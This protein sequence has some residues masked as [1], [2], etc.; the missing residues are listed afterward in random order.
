VQ[1]IA[2]RNLAFDR[3]FR[4]VLRLLGIAARIKHEPSRVSGGQQQRVAIAREIANSP[5][6]LL[7]DEPTDDLDNENS[8]AVLRLMKDLNHRLRPRILVITHDSG[9]DSYADRIVRMKNGCIV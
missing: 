2:N 9:A 3:A 6:I 4:E 5:V 1:S 8:T 7:T